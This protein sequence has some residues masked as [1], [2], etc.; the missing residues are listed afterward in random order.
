MYVHI[1]IYTHYNIDIHYIIIS[2]RALFY[3]Q[4]KRSKKDLKVFL[5]DFPDTFGDSWRGVCA[6]T[7][8][9]INCTSWTPW[10]ILCLLSVLEPQAPREHVGLGRLGRPMVAA[11][12]CSCRA[13]PWNQLTG[14]GGQN[15]QESGWQE[16]SAGPFPLHVQQQLSLTNLIA[17]VSGV[18][19]EVVRRHRLRNTAFGQ[20][21]REWIVAVASGCG[22]QHRLCRAI[23][24]AV[25]SVGS[26]SFSGMSRQ[27]RTSTLM[28]CY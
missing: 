12:F 8:G 5:S 17:S 20:S 9:R 6:T 26:I 4:K 28:G 3:Q 25:E 2:M 27:R 14:A 18:Q 11:G 22:F 21:L 13:H 24:P 19:E 1:Y 23:A 10:G 16:V 15:V 7:H